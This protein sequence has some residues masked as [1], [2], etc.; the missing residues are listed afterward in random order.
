MVA[1][2]ERE[3]PSHSDFRLKEAWPSLWKRTHRKTTESAFRGA[4]FSV[5]VG[6]AGGHVTVPTFRKSRRF[7]ACLLMLASSRTRLSSAD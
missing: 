4:S 3:T 6:G 2:W 7:C 5:A 1:A